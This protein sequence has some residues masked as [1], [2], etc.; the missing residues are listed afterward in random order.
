MNWHF[1]SFFI[2]CKYVFCSARVSLSDYVNTTF[3][4]LLWEL[5][6]LISSQND[7][8]DS[9]ILVR[10]LYGALERMSGF[11]EVDILC[12]AMSIKNKGW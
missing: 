12:N 9:E 2:E 11:A 6:L 7:I 5:N 8:N 10:Y 4:N 1:I 3:I